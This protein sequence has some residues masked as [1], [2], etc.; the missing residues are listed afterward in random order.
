MLIVVFNLNTRLLLV[1]LK[2]NSAFKDISDPYNPIMY[3][4]YVG[5]SGERKQ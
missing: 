3:T 4:A 2:I 1:K 5:H